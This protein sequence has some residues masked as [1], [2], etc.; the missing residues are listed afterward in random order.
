MGVFQVHNNDW[1]TPLEKLIKSK[2]W[3]KVGEINRA[4]CDENHNLKA[5]NAIRMALLKS[6]CK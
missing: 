2:K 6:V 1:V 4:Y 3:E 5:E